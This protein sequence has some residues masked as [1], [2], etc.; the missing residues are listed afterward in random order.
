MKKQL[1]GF[2]LALGVA[3]ALGVSDADAKERELAGW[4]VEGTGTGIVDGQ[5]YSLFNLDQKGYAKMQDR[6]GLNLGW[7][8]S[9]NNAMAIKHK[10]S[11]P[12][13]C[14]E[15]FALFVEKEWLMY[16]KQRFGINLSS[17]TQLKDEYY[18]WKFTSCTEGEVIQLNTPVTLTNTKEND[19]LV[20]AKRAI[21]VNVAWCDDT[22]T[23][24]G[25]NYRSADVPR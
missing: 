8:P 15:V 23:V 20:G 3:G 1:L 12:L 25:K 7:T 6:A 17:R 13:K 9:A 21:G 16:D 11:G 19:C 18:Q 4:R 22:T 5:K 24:R 10:G 14:G 2:G